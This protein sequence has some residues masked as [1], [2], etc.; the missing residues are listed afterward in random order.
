[1]KGHIQKD[2]SLT[3]QGQYDV[4][5]NF[6]IDNGPHGVALEVNLST[7][8]FSHMH[9]YLNREQALELANKIILVLQ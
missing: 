7:G 6:E 5:V 2:V 1:M 3:V 9:T 4:E 8:P